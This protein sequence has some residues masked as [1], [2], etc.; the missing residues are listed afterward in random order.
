[1]VTVFLLINPKSTGLFASGTALRGGG[2][3]HSLCEIRS[4]HPRKL[5]LLR[6]ID[7][8]MFYKIRK[9]ESPTITDDVIMTSLP[10]TAKMCFLLNWSHR[11]KS[12][13]HFCQILALSMI[14]THQI[15]SCHVTQDPNFENL[16]FR[17][18]STF[19]IR[20][21]HKIPCGKALCFRRY[22]QKPH[23]GVENS[24]QCL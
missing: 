11:V 17:L 21:S 7:Y 18:N 14:P 23:W 19:N 13:G 10:K 6:L 5:K 9:F 12:Y 3:F 22:Q 24:P 8:I 16:V 4:R 1:M 15:W 2:V 20:K